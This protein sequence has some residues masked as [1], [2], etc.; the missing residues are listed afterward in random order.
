MQE[1]SIPRASSSALNRPA[2]LSGDLPQLG[3]SVLG[4][5]LGGIFIG[6]PF[7]S[8]RRGP[9]K[10][11]GAAWGHSSR[12]IDHIALSHVSHGATMRQEGAVADAP[13]G[14]FNVARGVFNHPVFAREPFTERVSLGLRDP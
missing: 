9:R 7:A 8:P 2:L 12:A 10:G 13:L 3:Q 1:E 6:Y 11:G 4:I 5:G 14:T